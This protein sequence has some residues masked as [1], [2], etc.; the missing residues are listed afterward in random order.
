MPTEPSPTT[1]ENTEEN[2]MSRSGVST[3]RVE[4]RTLAQTLRV[5]TRNRPLESR[6]QGRPRLRKLVTRL[7]G[8]PP[9][10]ADRLVRRLESEGHF[11]W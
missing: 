6:R 3:A 2:V 9:P 7:L 4:L 5:C 10:E 11:A 8:C 1:R